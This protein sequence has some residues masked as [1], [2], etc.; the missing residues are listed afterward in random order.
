MT[1]PTMTPE[2]RAEKALPCNC[3]AKRGRHMMACPAQHREVF[4]GQIREAEQ[5]AVAREREG[6]IK[7]IGNTSRLI[8]T[9]NPSGATVEDVVRVHAHFMDITIEAIRARKEGG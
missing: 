8:R 7:I 3:R 9:K 5:A 6:C 1:E 2:E 4:A